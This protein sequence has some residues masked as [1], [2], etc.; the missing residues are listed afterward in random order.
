M[1]T[2]ALSGQMIDGRYRV[3]PV[4]GAGGFGVVY[5]ATHLGL[6]GKVA[7]KV[8]RVADVSRAQLAELTAS[9]FEEGRLLKRVRHPNVVVAAPHLRRRRPRHGPL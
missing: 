2:G 7:L 1:E 6:H 8:P 3:G 5:A 9:F 4:I